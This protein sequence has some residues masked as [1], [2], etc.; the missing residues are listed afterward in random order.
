M[1]NSSDNE[2]ML[3]ERTHDTLKEKEFLNFISLMRLV[4][5]EYEI[6]KTRKAI[7]ASVREF[8]DMVRVFPSGTSVPRG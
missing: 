8:A 1:D 4:K 5:D 2:K 6:N 7:D 3:E